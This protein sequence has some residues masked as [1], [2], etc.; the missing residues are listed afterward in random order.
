MPLLLRPS[1]IFRTVEPIYVAASTLSGAIPLELVNA[2]A[3]SEL[4]LTGNT[5]SVVLQF[6]ILSLCDL[7]AVLRMATL[8]PE[9]RKAR[10]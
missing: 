5:L 4:N 1:H 8:S 2:P 3:L 10:H 7:I 9:T 6:S